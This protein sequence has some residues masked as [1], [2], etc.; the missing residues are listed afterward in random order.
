MTS[1]S[2]RT[3]FAIAV[4]VAFAAILILWPHTASRAADNNKPWKAVQPDY[5]AYRQV[6]AG[7]DESDVTTLLGQP[8]AK[9]DGFDRNTDVIYGWEYGS[10]APKSLIF[11]RPPVFRILFHKGK[12]FSRE[13]PFHGHFS[14]DGTPTVPHPLWPEEAPVYHFYPRYIDLRWSASSGV[15]PMSY[16]I[17]IGAFTGGDRDDLKNWNTVTEKSTLPFLAHEFVGDQPGHWRVR[18]INAKGSSGW[19]DYSDFEFDNGPGGMHVGKPN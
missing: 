6:K 16:E 8:L 10:I 17:E 7:M 12:V 2:S 11:P 9:P 15:Y 19:S 3:R 18:A 5:D 4:W 13:D 1:P 14:K